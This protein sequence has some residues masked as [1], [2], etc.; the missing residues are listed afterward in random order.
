MLHVFSL[1]LGASD[2]KKAAKD[3]IKELIKQ[4]KDMCPHAADATC[5]ITRNKES[6]V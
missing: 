1:F 2:V 3:R 6:I 4:V 5:N